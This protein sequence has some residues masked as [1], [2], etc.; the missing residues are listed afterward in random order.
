MDCLEYLKALPD[1]CVDLIVTDPPYN[2]SQKS[3]LRFGDRFIKKNFGEWD[4]GFD[5]VPVLRELRRV[6][7]PH[8]QI[9]VFCGNEQIPVY[10]Q[11]FIKDWFFRNL[12]VW[13]K[14]NPPPR[15]SKTN[16]VFSNEFIV[17]AIKEKGRPGLATFNFSSQSTMKNMFITSLLL[18]KERLRGGDG[19][20][21]HPTQ[22]PLLI[23]KKL[24]EV[25]SNPG[26]VVL[27]PFM[28]VGSTAVACKE[29][30]RNFIG[31]EINSLY[32]GL[33][34]KRLS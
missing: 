25:S 9:Y 17:Y 34:N 21:V 22:K 26:D 24:I 27:D 28:G 2:V 32:V 3:D 29:L 4:F 16:Y 11:I 14:T 23:L 33:A 30:G 1:E 15:L 6:L 5:P 13:H 19:L 10:M 18:G 12:L 7:K 8:G 20:A 31:C